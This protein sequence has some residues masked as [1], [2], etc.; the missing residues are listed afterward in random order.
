MQQIT[1][2]LTVMGEDVQQLMDRR[3]QSTDFSDLLRPLFHPGLRL[4]LVML[5]DSHAAEDAVQEAMIVAWQ[6]AG[7]IREPEKLNA[8]FLGVVANKCRNARRGVWMSRVLLGVPEQLNLVSGEQ[9]ALA[10]ED[11][12]RAVAKLPYEDRLVIALYYYLDLPLERVA[13]VTRS[14]VSATRARLYRAIK[15]LRPD[16]D[17]EEELR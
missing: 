13:A 11:L 4:A 10:G 5:H 12:R 16:V 8:W 14:S 7:S 1:F 6:K 17:I 15:R 3:R 2:S 9:R